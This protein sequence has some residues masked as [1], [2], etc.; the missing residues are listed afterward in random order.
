MIEFG[1]VN[2]TIERQNGQVVEILGFWVA[3][4]DKG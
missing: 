2:V 1:I 4:S 3:D